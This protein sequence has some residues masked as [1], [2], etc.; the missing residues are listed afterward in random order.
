MAAI[1]GK[2]CLQEFYSFNNYLDC[3]MIHIIAYSIDMED[4]YGF[5]NC[6]ITIQTL[7]DLICSSLHSCYTCNISFQF[8]IQLLMFS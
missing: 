1:V 5:S 7:I 3:Y 2:L 8:T 4:T 6:L